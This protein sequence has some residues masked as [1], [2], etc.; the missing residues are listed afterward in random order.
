MLRR[1]AALRK[2]AKDFCAAIEEEPRKNL[3]CCQG[4]RK[5]PDNHNKVDGAE[6]MA[7][8]LEEV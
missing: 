2:D 5:N 6:K 4:F 3:F 8:P 1:W 7:L